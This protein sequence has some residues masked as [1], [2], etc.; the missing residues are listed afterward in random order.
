[1]ISPN[2]KRKSAILTALVYALLP[3]AQICIRHS[4]KLQDILEAVKL[5]F[6]KA[7]E[8]ELAKSD[9]KMSVSRI[10]VMTGVN[11]RDVSRL[12]DGSIDVTRFP[13]LTSRVLGAWQADKRFLTDSGRPRVLSAEGRESEFSELV[14]AISSDVAPYTVLHELERLGIVERTSSGVKMVS[15]IYVNPPENFE[16]TY[17]MLGEDA[18]DLTYAI[19]SN[20]SERLETPNLHLKTEYSNISKRDLPTVREWLLTEGSAFHRKVRHYLSGYDLDLNPEIRKKNSGTRVVYASYSHAEGAA[21]TL[22][23]EDFTQGEHN[24]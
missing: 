9:E 3:L 6:I 13:D 14:K 24:E 20:L 12:L 7:S 22:P 11:R 23:A 1:M 16:E 19:E 2:E 5:A 10:S 17:I 15:R 8:A 21:N 4:I 18:R